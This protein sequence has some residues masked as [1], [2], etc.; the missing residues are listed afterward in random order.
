MREDKVGQERVVQG[1]FSVSKM[2]GGE[3]NGMEVRGV[4]GKSKGRGREEGGEGE[5]KM[6][7][8]GKGRGKGRGKGEGLS[9]STFLL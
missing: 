9:E 7:G 8:K 2:G 6:E 3:K 1:H 5:G 4:E